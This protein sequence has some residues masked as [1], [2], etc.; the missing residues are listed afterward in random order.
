MRTFPGTRRGLLLLLLA[1]ASAHAQPP[2]P[3]CATPE[4]HQFDFLI[5]DWDAYDFGQPKP[6]ARVR[7]EPILDGCV[8]RETYQGF[9]GLAGESLNTY[10]A[11]RKLWHQSWVTN[12]GQL[13]MIEGRFVDGRMTLEGQTIE[14]DGQPLM[15]R[16]VW[17]PVAS[18][19]RHTAHT[20]KDRGRTWS[21]LFDLVFKRHI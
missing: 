10:D 6:A 20:S 2:Q 17:T 9:D 13:L 14:P 21:L 15:W 19:I 12:R 7:I 4:Q 16:A 1:S 18:E 8:L 3:R 5:G 11:S